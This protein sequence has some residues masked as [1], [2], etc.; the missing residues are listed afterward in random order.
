MM[1]GRRDVDPS[2]LEGPGVRRI[3]DRERAGV[4]Q[5]AREEVVAWGATCI[6][7][8]TAAGRSAGSA[9]MMVRS[10]CTPPADAP[11]TITSRFAMASSRDRTAS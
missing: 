11:M 6:T 4:R 3:D 1:I 7:T 2:V 5:D 9:R 8:E 10:A